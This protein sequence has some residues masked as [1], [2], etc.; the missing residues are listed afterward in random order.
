MNCVPYLFLASGQVVDKRV[1][2]TFES[3]TSH[4]LFATKDNG[5]TIAVKCDNG[6]GKCQKVTYTSVAESWTGT[7]PAVPVYP[8]NFML[9]HKAKG[10]N[11]VQV[12]H[13]VDASQF[14]PIDLAQLTV[15][16]A[17]ALAREHS[18]VAGVTGSVTLSQCEPA[19]TSEGSTA[20]WCASGALPFYTGV[21]HALTDPDLHQRVMSARSCTIM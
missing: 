13:H 6:T 14:T 4:F 16:P 3:A 2:P 10:S 20:V 8:C 15:G 7:P 12:A 11:P 5:H 9:T 19:S 17:A 21:R 18:Y 1:T